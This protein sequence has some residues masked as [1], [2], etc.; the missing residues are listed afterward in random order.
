[1]EKLAAL[2]EL[3]AGVAHQVNNPG[4]STFTIAS[5]SAANQAQGMS[6]LLIY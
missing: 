3:A 2:G 4:R 5:G 1:M 6:G